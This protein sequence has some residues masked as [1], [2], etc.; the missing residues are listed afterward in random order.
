M[1]GRSDWRTQAEMNPSI[2]DLTEQMMRTGHTAA[3]RVRHFRVVAWDWDV[4]GNEGNVIRS[5]VMRRS[6]VRGG[7]VKSWVCEKDRRRTRVVT[8]WVGPMA[9]RAGLCVV[10]VCTR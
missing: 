8:G 6:R 10:M 2:V 5:W 7:N 4:K 9:D 3:W 1:C